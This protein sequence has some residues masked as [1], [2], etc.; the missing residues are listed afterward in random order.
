MDRPTNSRLLTP[1]STLRVPVGFV[2]IALLGFVVAIVIAF[3][4]GSERG[5]RQGRSEVESIRQSLGRVESAGGRMREPAAV[6]AGSST[7]DVV[8]STPPEPPSRPDLPPLPAGSERLD[9]TV[10]VV[11][12]RTRPGWTYKV[13]LFTK[14][15]NA[16][17]VAESIRENGRD[18]GI[19]AMVLR[20]DNGPF[21][22]VILLPGSPTGFSREE[23]GNWDWRIDEILAGRLADKFNW[24]DKRPFSGHFPKTFGD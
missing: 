2:W 10:P 23:L 20:K 14:L 6:P 1:G 15:E 21:G 16:R 3:W 5:L 22:H 7:T 12:D 13:V 9:R 8:D 11:Q 24:S 17:L 18:L 19:D 4:V